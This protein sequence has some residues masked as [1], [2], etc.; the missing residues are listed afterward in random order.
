VTR[1]RNDLASPGEPPPKQS[2]IFSNPFFEGWFD[3]VLAGTVFGSWLPIIVSAGI[4]EGLFSGFMGIIFGWMFAC[5]FCI[6][7]VPLIAL[8]GGVI[9]VPLARGLRGALIMMQRV[10]SDDIASVIT[11]LLSLLKFREILCQHCLRYTHPSRSRYQDGIRYCEHCGQTVEQTRVPG[12][13]VFVFGAFN[14]AQLEPIRSEQRMFLKVNP[15]FVRETAPVDVS[16]VYLDPGTC[17]RR[18]FE[19][20]ITFLV[21]HPPKHGLQAVQIMYTGHL[22]DLGQHLENAINNTFTNIQQLR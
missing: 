10:G 4:G 8:L 20:F 2:G 3:G 5:A 14:N 6:F 13:V 21:N 22:N 12:R 15:D 11:P 18:Q 19:R 7:T 17:N 9:G 1:I 16:T